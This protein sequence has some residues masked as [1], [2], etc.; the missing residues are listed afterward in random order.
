MTNIKYLNIQI[1]IGWLY[2]PLEGSPQPKRNEAHVEHDCGGRDGHQVEIVTPMVVVAG[3]LQVAWHIA[4][5]C[6]AK[7]LYV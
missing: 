5:D 1:G 7:N 4:T 2:K 3:M 6:D